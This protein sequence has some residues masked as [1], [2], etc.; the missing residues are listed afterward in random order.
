MLSETESAIGKGNDANDD[1]NNPDDARRFHTKAT[2]GLYAASPGDEVNHQDDDR[3][4][5]QDVD[6]S[7]KGIRAD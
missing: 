3:E 5:Q 7:T 2:N 1:K 6:E 4:H